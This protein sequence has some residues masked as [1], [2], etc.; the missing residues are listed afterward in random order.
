MIGSTIA[1]MTYRGSLGEARDGEEIGR[2]GALSATR[3]PDGMVLLAEG[4]R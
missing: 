3:P 4:R 1:R 2:L